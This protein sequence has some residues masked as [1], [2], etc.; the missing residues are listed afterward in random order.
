VSNEEITYT[1]AIEEADA[2]VHLLSRV[3]AATPDS[4]RTNR[5]DALVSAR[6]KLRKKRGR[7]LT[8]E[9][10]AEI[11]AHVA[12]VTELRRIKAKNYPSVH[13]YRS[14]KTK[15]EKDAARTGYEAYRRAHEELRR[16][17]ALS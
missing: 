5:D 4:A 10:A 16:L 15:G 13:A 9:V 3:L 12:K 8:P 14:A 17:G 11:D 6:S 1:F 2:L 7:E